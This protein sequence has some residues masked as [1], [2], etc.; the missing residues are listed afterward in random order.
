[1]SKKTGKAKRADIAPNNVHWLDYRKEH[2]LPINND[3]NC[4]HISSEN[5]AKLREAVRK[6]GGKLEIDKQAGEE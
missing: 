1:M 6:Q 2:N 4:I 5:L 3:S